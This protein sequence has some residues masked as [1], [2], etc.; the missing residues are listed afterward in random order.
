MGLKLRTLLEINSLTDRDKSLVAADADESKKC[1]DVI[2]GL[3]AI[4]S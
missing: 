3:Q 2:Y 1:K 4:L